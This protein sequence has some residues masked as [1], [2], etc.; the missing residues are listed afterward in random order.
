MNWLTQEM[1]AVIG[2]VLAFLL[3]HDEGRG[4]GAGKIRG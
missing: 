4:P 3:T 1:A 2:F